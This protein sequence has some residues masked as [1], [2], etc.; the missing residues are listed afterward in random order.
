VTV[1]S[2]CCISESG[3]ATGNATEKYRVVVGFIILT[4]EHMSYLLRSALLVITSNYNH[5]YVLYNLYDV[6]LLSLT[7]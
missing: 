1:F 4:L 2:V 6:N 3:S 5:M 7:P